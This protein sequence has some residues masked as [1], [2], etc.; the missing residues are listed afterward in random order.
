[1]FA[2]VPAGSKS[3]AGVASE[4]IRE[5]RGRGSNCWDSDAQGALTETAS[6]LSRRGK[7]DDTRWREV[8]SS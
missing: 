3:R 6:W 4:L 8:V 1:M 2:R 5:N 7:Q